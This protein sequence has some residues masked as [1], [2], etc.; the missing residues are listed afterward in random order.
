MS[1]ELWVVRYESAYLNLPYS[2]TTIWVWA[3]RKDSHPVDFLW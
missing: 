2:L 3:G 1:C